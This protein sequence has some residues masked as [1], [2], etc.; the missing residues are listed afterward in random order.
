LGV[1]KIEYEW[2]FKLKP[3]DKLL[4]WWRVGAALAAA[5]KAMSSVFDI[6]CHDGYLLHRVDNGKRR[7]DGCDPRLEIASLPR[8]SRLLQG[9]FPAVMA[10]V[11]PRGPYDA[12]FALAVFEHFTESDLT[13]SS[14][15]IAEMLSTKGRLLVT[16]PHPFVDRILDMLMFL[17]LIDGQ[18][19]EE[20]HGFDPASL[21]DILSAHLKLVSRKTFQMRLNNLF[22]FERI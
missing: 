18:A 10:D 12:I 1:L 21:V 6:G 14:R 22:V 8:D 20:H 5:P 2:G 13:E 9:F 16:V 17:N 19:L 11:E 15:K 4:R 7:L 3:I